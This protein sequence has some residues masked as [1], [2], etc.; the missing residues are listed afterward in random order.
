MYLLRWVYG[1][2]ICVDCEQLPPQNIAECWPDY[3]CRVVDSCNTDTALNGKVTLS[4]RLT[5]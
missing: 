2:I 5:N 3:G 4:L 1:E